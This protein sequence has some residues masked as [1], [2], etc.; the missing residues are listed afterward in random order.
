MEID[1]K[2]IDKFLSESEVEMIENF[3]MENCPP[4]PSYNPLKVFSGDYY[5]FNFYDPKFAPVTDIL[6]PKLKDVFGGKLYLHQIHVFDC[7][8][9][10]DIH[11]DVESGP[12]M[13]PEAPHYAWTLIIPLRD[14]DSHTI[15]FKEK[16]RTKDLGEYGKSV[17]PYE[18]L[19]I[20]D[21]TYQKYFTHTSKGC[22]NL[23]TIEDVF[24]WKKGALFAADRFKFH[25][26]DNFLANG[27]KS[28]RA[29]V[30]WTTLRD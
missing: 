11:S 1:T 3:I 19:T 20:D 16:S 9:P 5:I 25:C 14:V 26:S 21:E 30:A 24:K 6:W 12:A 17:K 13:N 27:V 4:L 7:F 8:N 22:F 10:Y 29:I 15:V 23:L 2:T 28:K 18:K